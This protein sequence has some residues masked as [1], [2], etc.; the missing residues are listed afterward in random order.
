MR[1]AISRFFVHSSLNVITWLSLCSGGSGNYSL[2]GG[3]S[4]GVEH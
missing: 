1:T 4:F 3:S 2:G